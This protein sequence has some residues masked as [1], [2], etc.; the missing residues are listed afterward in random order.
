[1]TEPAEPAEPEEHR[2]PPRRRRRITPIDP[3]LSPEQLERI[4]GGE[5]EP[6]PD[7]QL[8]D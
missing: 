3:R 8:D 2:E 6:A 5:T 7:R 4:V 1:M